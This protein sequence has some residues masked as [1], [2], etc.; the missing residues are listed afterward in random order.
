MEE[1]AWPPGPQGCSGLH[2]RPRTHHWS[3]LREGWGWC[4][5]SEPQ[6]H[7][8]WG[9]TWPWH[10]LGQDIWR[11][12]YTAKHIPLLS[13]PLWW[14]CLRKA[15]KTRTFKPSL[16]ILFSHDKKQTS[17]P[18]LSGLVQT[19]EKFSHKANVFR[20]WQEDGGRDRQTDIFPLVKF[21]NIEATWIAFLL[22]LL[23]KILLRFLVPHG[24]TPHSYK[25]MLPG[26]SHDVL[27][28]PQ[29]PEP[30]SVWWSLRKWKLSRSLPWVNQFPCLTTPQR[31][32]LSRGHESESAWE[33]MISLVG[34]SW[35][36]SVL[37]GKYFCYPS[38]RGKK[39]KQ[40]LHLWQGS[41]VTKSGKRM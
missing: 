1:E 31:V 37:C 28:I 38:A 3:S 16:N 34:T 23:G 33:D 40:K 15:S 13:A 12:G 6:T 30:P 25:W 9:S 29:P 39:T 26:Q 7:Q 19:L 21:C 17:H 18:P 8:S 20:G 27:L 32:E 14:W 35:G 41:W 24:F 22:P 10:D 11:R 5:A 4:W 2:G 36:L